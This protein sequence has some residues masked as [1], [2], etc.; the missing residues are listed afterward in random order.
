VTERRLVG[1]C[2]IEYYTREDLQHQTCTEKR[3][4]WLLSSI[5]EEAFAATAPAW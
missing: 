3:L 2:K 4:K 5:H 1:Q